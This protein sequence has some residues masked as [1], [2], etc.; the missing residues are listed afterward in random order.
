MTTIAPS[1]MRF[2][3]TRDCSTEGGRNGEGTIKVVKNI[4]AEMHLWKVRDDMMTSSWCGLGDP[5]EVMLWVEQRFL[6]NLLHDN[7][8]FNV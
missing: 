4:L 8:H 7:P 2:S 5:S 6:P 3:C 1:S